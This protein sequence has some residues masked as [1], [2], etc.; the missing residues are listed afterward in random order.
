MDIDRISEL[1]WASYS[2]GKIEIGVIGVDTA[3]G[4]RVTIHLLKSLS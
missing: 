3:W 1:C 4:G 2:D